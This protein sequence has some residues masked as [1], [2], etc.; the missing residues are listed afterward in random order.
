M[1]SRLVS[2]ARKQR[3]SA[4]TSTATVPLRLATLFMS[5]VA[6]LPW[7]WRIGC[8]AHAPKAP[9]STAST[10]I[11]TSVGLDTARV[12]RYSASQSVSQWQ[13]QRSV[14]TSVGLDTTV[15]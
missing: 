9:P 15:R 6:T 11:A 1:S 3:M 7:M 8:C 13:S 10:H 5:L 14:D 4:S 12:S 2:S